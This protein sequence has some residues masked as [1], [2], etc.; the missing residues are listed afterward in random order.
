V[1]AIHLLKPEGHLAIARMAYV[2]SSFTDPHKRTLGRVLDFSKQC[3]E[4]VQVHAQLQAVSGFRQPNSRKPCMLIF[5]HGDEFLML[6]VSFEESAATRKPID[7][8]EGDRR[9]ESPH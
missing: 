8:E 4:L 5:R 7:T 2:S 9:T 6:L 1:I 3:K